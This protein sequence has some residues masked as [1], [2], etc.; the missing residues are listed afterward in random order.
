MNS[1][2]RSPIIKNTYFFLNQKYLCYLRHT[3]FLY[4]FAVGLELIVDEKTKQIKDFGEFPEYKKRCRNLK[5]VPNTFLIRHA[6]EDN[7]KMRH[8]YMTSSD[9]RTISKE[10][11]V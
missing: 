11:E 8:R 3:L 6:T 10:V 9:C 7:F 4:I 5:V 1:Q 2:G